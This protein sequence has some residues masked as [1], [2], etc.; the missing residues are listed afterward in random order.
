[1]NIAICTGFRDDDE[2]YSICNVAN[3]QIKMFV[4]NGYKLKVLVTKGFVPTRNFAHPNVTIC[5]MPDQTRQNTITVDAA[6]NE[7]VEALYISMEEHL[8]D[9]DIVLTHD[10]VYQPGDLK[11]NIALRRYAENHKIRFLHWIHSAT[12]PYKLVDLMGIFPEKYKEVVGKRFPNSYYIF[13]NYWSKPR[14]ESAYNVGEEEVKIIHHPT[15]Y[16]KFAKFH[17]I[18]VKIVNARKLLEKDHIIV[19]PARL[20]TGKQLEYPIKLIASLKRLGRSV[21]FI[22]CDFHSSSDDPKDP[23]LIY[24]NELKKIA[25]EWGLTPEDYLFT[26]EFMPELK[27]R[28]P[29]EVVSDLFDI[30][31]IFFMSSGSESYSLVTQEA[32]MKGNLLILNRNFPPFT[33]I[34][35][36][37][38]LLFPCQSGVQIM[39]RIEGE[40]STKFSDEKEAYLTLAKQVEAN[41]ATKQYKTRR[42]LLKE[43]TPEYIF[44]NELEPLL[45]QIMEKYA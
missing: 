2:A 25:G 40:T 39:D 30:S 44:K 36:E 13:F 18:S 12:S 10:L 24:R 14:I 9:V 32:A 17:P 7:D 31:N 5:E 23:K 6:F 1:M 4:D 22:A 29:S 35:G 28:V 34:F 37:D 33:E 38:N 26:S 42:K 3:D 41:L 8:K 27:V 15:D 19:Y 21:Q 20:D 11:H 16:M 43:R 45:F